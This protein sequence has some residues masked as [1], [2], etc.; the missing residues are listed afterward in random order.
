[1]KGRFCHRCQDFSICANDPE[2]DVSIGWCMRHDRD[3]SANQTCDDFEA[4]RDSEPAMSDFNHVENPNLTKFRVKL[5]M[6]AMSCAYA[7]VYCNTEAEA[8]DLV[9]D[10]AMNGQI[11]KW[12]VEDE[13]IGA[14]EVIYAEAN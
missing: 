3:T 5:A 4:E 6:P 2:T 13:D 8:R 11:D 9:Y 12:V 14:L 7:E 10:A 1:M